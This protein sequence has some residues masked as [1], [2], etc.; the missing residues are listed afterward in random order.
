MKRRILAVLAAAACG[1]ATVEAH[2]AL[3]IV[4]AMDKTETIEGDLM[5]LRWQNPHSLVLVNV[6]DR[7]GAVLRYSVEWEASLQLTHQGVTRQTLKVGDHLIITGNPGRR[8]GD[9]LLRLRTIFRPKDSWRWRGA[10][11]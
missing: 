4:Y 1:A 2:H 9:H 3:A 5:E 11:E 6:R 8:P 10:F 7:T